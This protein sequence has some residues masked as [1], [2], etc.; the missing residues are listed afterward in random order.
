MS[1]SSLMEVN[2]KGRFK[3][4]KSRVKA[5]I[6]GQMAGPMRASGFKIKCTDTAAFSGKTESSTSVSLR[7]TNER[8]TDCSAG[9]TG[10]FTK[11]SGK[12]INNT[13]LAPSAK[14]ALLLAKGFGNGAKTLNGWTSE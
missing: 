13:A 5:N 11:A 6:S 14:Q 7:L 2:T 4:M 9:M 8:V 1:F 12:T 10:V 3:R